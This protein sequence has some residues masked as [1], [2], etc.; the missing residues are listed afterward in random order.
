MHLMPLTLTLSGPFIGDDRAEFIFQLV[1]LS[2]KLYW[3]VREIACCHQY[4]KFI[5]LMYVVCSFG[6]KAIYRILGRIFI[7]VL[8]QKLMVY[9]NIYQ[10]TLSTAENGIRLLSIIDVLA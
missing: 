3:S 7:L 9:L 2:F 4:E 5:K 1:V 6:T 10:L 8:C